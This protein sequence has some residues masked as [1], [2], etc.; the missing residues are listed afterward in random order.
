[1]TCLDLNTISPAEL[2]QQLSRHHTL[3][4]C[5][6]A[7]WCDVCAAYRP[8]FEGFAE[9]HPEKLFLWVDIEDQ[10]ELVEDVNVENFPTLLI[11]QYGIVTFFGTMQPDTK[12]LKRLLRAQAEQTLEQLQ[13]QTATNTQ[14]RSWQSEANLLQKLVQRASI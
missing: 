11:Q 13:Q 8:Q 12:Q 2:Q 4:A 5:L 14:Q 6:C 1:M 10:A 7:A 9:Q 3:V